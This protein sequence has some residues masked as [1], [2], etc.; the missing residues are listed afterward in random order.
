[1]SFGEEAPRI[2]LELLK[3][4]QPKSRLVLETKHKVEAYREKKT[5]E[6]SVEPVD[7]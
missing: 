4:L 7:I 3:S 1:M 5:T 6:G 2:L